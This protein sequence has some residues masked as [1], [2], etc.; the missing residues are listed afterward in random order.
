MYIYIYIS[1]E[2]HGT[3]EWFNERDPVNSVS[4]EPQPRQYNISI[5]NRILPQ[6]ALRV[7]MRLP[8]PAVRVRF[9]HPNPA[10]GEGGWLWLGSGMVYK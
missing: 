1:T 4:S 7:G 3:S 8:C 10:P 5:V 6:H 2:V 9:F